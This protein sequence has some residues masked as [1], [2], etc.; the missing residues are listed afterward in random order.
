MDTEDFQQ[1][2][3][4]KYQPELDQARQRA[5]YHQRFAKW[6]EWILII[7]SAITTILLAFSSFLNG[8]SVM[9]LTAICSAIVT[10]IATTMKSLKT[11]EKWSFYQKLGN[12]LDNEYYLYSSG[13]G[14]YQ[15]F[16]DKQAQFVKRVIAL[17]NEAD[18]KMP[19]R[20][21]LDA[22]SRH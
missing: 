16:S 1:F 13:E 5:R 14:V 20:T 4:N 12:D 15:K 17:L 19:R 7:F 3:R 2:L 18:R 6:S 9:P 8:L 10:V 22:Y 21:L 11:Q